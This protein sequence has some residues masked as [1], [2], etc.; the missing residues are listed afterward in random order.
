MPTEVP[1][2]RQTDIGA[3]AAD[4]T[5]IIVEAFH[6]RSPSI[7][8]KGERDPAAYDDD[9]T[10]GGVGFMYAEYRLLVREEYSEQVVE[11]VRAE[12]AA[13]L[14]TSPVVRGVLLL[15]WNGEGK[16]DNKSA[17]SDDDNPKGDDRSTE[18]DGGIAQGNSG[19]QDGRQTPTVLYLVA[20]IEQRYG[21]GVA[22][23]DQVLTASNGEISHCPA[24]E[25]EEF[26]GPKKPYPPA[27]DDDGG[28]GVRIFI[29]DTGLLQDATEQAWLTEHKWLEGVT[30]DDFDPATG[31]NGMIPQYAG[32]GTFVA[33][34]VRCMA[35]KA[36]ILVAN[37]FNTAGSALESDFVLRLND[38]FD[39]GF[40][41]LHITASCLTWNNQQLIALDA[42]LE[43]LKAY[44]GVVCIAPAGNNHTRRPSWPG[45]LRGV[46]CV[47]A[48]STDWRSRAY[49]SNY[50]SYV[51]V[52]AP[53]Q[54][55]VNAYA[56]G[57]YQCQI[58]PYQGQ[59]RTFEG[60]AQWSGTS[61]S[62]PVVTGLIAARMTRCGES[63]R[64]A[65]EALLAIARKQRI[66]GVGPVLLPDRG[67]EDCGCGRRDRR[68]H[69]C[70]C[71]GRSGCGCARDGGCGCDVRRGCG[72]GCRCGEGGRRLP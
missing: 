15:T 66:P 9:V 61:F 36:T 52:Y 32:H 40:E 2:Y 5:E 42:W 25:P 18:G 24:T 70:E 53:G 34:V 26:Y 13:N 71:G 23:P 12:G 37:I 47:G 54:N 22:T 8:I 59:Q 3:R 6:N 43:Q 57:T 69:G 7:E 67:D 60:M 1:W 19:A 50:G 65:A 68:D 20:L 46:L 27:R 63:A 30:C 39:F 49:F 44:K 48:L 55:L 11:L 29:A 62:T 31:A 64:E 45:A 16:S 10:P 21:V 72:A 38:A 14:Q 28:R 33:G 56:T 35:P 51:D 4:E 41:I 17:K 58:D